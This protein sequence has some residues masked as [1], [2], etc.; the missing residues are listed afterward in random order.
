MKQNS[1]LDESNI[2]S[3][4][5]IEQANPCHYF[6]QVESLC[7]SCYAKD[8]WP[9][10][11]KLWKGKNKTEPGKLIR[12]GTYK[13][14]TLLE[15]LKFKKLFPYREYFLI[16]RGFQTNLYEKIL[17]DPYGFNIQIS[18]D[19]HDDGRIIPPLEMLEKL[20]LNKK[21]IFRFKTELHNMQHFVLLAEVLDLPSERILET[22][23]RYRRRK[24]HKLGDV[25]PF[26]SVGF[27]SYTCNS[28]CR[29]CAIENGTNVNICSLKL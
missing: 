21:V 13:E 5:E 25:T 29:D 17:E 6:S 16:S 26:E 11:N 24:S 1:K 27:N 22:P 8:L 23:Q 4:P 20:K 12:L 28:K 15:W 9:V 14:I 10:R 7:K 19:I 18:V 3:C 2:T